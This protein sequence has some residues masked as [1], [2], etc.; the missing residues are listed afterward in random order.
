MADGGEAWRRERQ[1]VDALQADLHAMCSEGKKKC[2]AVKLVSACTCVCCV[3]V[4]TLCESLS[5][6]TVFGFGVVLFAG[7]LEYPVL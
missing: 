6:L 2:P 7:I 5:G 3:V 1:L 4:S